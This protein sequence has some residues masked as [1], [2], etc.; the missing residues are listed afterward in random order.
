[1]GVN[2]QILQNIRLL[3]ELVSNGSL[4]Q[5]EI[6]EYL[7][8]T[9]QTLSKIF[10]GGVA[11]VSEKIQDRVRRLCSDDGA[12][13]HR[14]AYEVIRLFRAM[15]KIL[16]HSSK[17]SIEEIEHTRDILKYTDYWIS[18]K[19]PDNYMFK[20]S[21]HIQNFHMK[22]NP[23]YLYLHEYFHKDL[24]PVLTYDI[25]YDLN[26]IHNVT[27]GNIVSSD[28]MSKGYNLQYQTMWSKHCDKNTLTFEEFIDCLTSFYEGKLRYN[29]YIDHIDNSQDYIID[30]VSKKYKDK[31]KKVYFNDLSRI[32]NVVDEFRPMEEVIRN[33]IPN[34]KQEKLLTDAAYRNAK[35]IQMVR[36]V[37]G[38]DI[39]GNNNLLK[40]MKSSDHETYVKDHEISR[41]KL[42]RRQ[43][44]MKKRR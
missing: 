22:S 6:A 38:Y 11:D 12:L 34:L 35:I 40:L 32:F 39:P 43:K 23:Y 20:L 33:Y 36:I 44:K 42:E 26:R 4:K 5:L 27:L 1:M 29:I 25:D 16:D 10:K 18:E 28:Y 15:N 17:L 14:R 7:G 13:E 19:S 8:I 9:R 21:C 3:N 37:G 24:A 30:H 31:F 2:R 41:E